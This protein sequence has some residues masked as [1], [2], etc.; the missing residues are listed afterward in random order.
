MMLKEKNTSL[1]CIPWMVLAAVAIACASFFHHI[2]YSIPVSLL[3]SLSISILIYYPLQERLIKEIRKMQLLNQ[4]VAAMQELP[5]GICLSNTHGRILWSNHRAEQYLRL[6]TET[7]EKELNL[8]NLLTEVN[9]TEI[10]RKPRRME[11]QPGQYIEY[12]ITQLSDGNHYLTY[13]TDISE[14]IFL[15]NSRKTLFSN[16][17]HE[18]RIPLTVLRGYIEILENEKKEEKRERDKLSLRPYKNMR[19]QVNRLLNMV[20]Q[21]LTLAKIEEKP[22][23]EEKEIV[24]MPDI[25]YSI[26]DETQIRNIHK[27]K[28]SLHL[29]DELFTEG[30][31]QPLREAISNLI[32]NAI[33]HNPKNCEIEIRWQRTIRDDQEVALFSISDNGIGIAKEHLDRITERFYMVNS[34]RNRSSNKKT[35]SGLGLAIVKNALKKHGSELYIESEETVGSC[36]KFYLPVVNNSQQ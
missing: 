9:F 13:M 20:D 8:F 25:I 24:D 28:I 16:I 2:G 7:P 30:Y 35:G 11:I 5:V 29:D 26:Y 4:M 3:V 32:Y 15:E 14:R 17:S 31:A 10:P 27:Q 18:L 12:L 36:F 6:G 23:Y 19:T 21:L 1:V 22:F 33:E 34:A